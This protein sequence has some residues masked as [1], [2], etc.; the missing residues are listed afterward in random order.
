LRHAD[1]GANLRIGSVRGTITMTL[2]PADPDRAIEVSKELEDIRGLLE[3]MGD[4]LL[5]VGERESLLVEI[6]EAKA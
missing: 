4:R 1:P 6:Q 3:V 5:V 2:S